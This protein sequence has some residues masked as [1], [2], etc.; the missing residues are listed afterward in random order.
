VEEKFVKRYHPSTTFPGIDKLYFKGF[1]LPESRYLLQLPLR[2]P[3]LLASS[4]SL[5]QFSRLV[6][7]S[8]G[9]E[10]VHLR[11]VAKRFT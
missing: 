11:A 3:L 8:F 7:D 6:P 10:V 4:C 2:V 1:V 5:Q 9:F